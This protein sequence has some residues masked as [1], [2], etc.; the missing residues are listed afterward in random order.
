MSS[1][2]SPLITQ[3]Q[4]DPNLLERFHDTAV[5]LRTRLGRLAGVGLLVASGTLATFAAEE[6]VS[7]TPAYA[8]TL[9]YPWPTDTEAPCQFGATGSSSCTNPSNPSDKYDWGVNTGGV[10]HPYREAGGYEYRNCTD[11]VAWKEESLGASSSIVNGL[12]NG[13]QW[14]N[15]APASERSLTPRAGDAAVDTSGTFGHVA[16]VESVNYA[17][18]S[19]PLNDNITVSEY[20]HDIQGHGD[21]R[22]GKVSDLGFSKFVDFGVHPTGSTTPNPTSPNNQSGEGITMPGHWISGDSGQDFA[23]ITRRA[24]DGFDVAV[25]E[26]TPAGLVWKGVMQSVLGSSGVTYENTKFVATDMDGDGLMDLYYA[27]SANW[28]NPGFAMALFHNNGNGLDYWGQQWDPTNIALGQTKFLPGNWAGNG[29]GAFDYVTKNSD[30]GFS[31]AEFKSTASGLVWDGV[32]WT[33]AGSSGVTY[34]NTKFMPS[35]MDGDGKTDLYYA[36]ASNWAQPGF[37]MALQYNNGNGFTWAGQ[38]W[39]PNNLALQDVRL[40]PG[41]WTGTGKEGFAYITKN[42]DGGFSTAVF[43]STL[44]GLVWKGVWWTS[45]GSSQ[46]SYNNTL[47]VPADMDNDGKTDLFYAT[48]LNWNNPGFATA[49]MHSNGA[50]YDYWGQQW[51]PTNIALSQVTFMPES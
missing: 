42:S 28:N 18:P 33:S 40:I 20:N 7:S 35:D 5:D 24:D 32:R 34:D 49:L 36:T 43:D 25:W 9:G 27:T 1:E 11:Y 44:T 4:T 16:Y 45:P 51:D 8:D 21:F 26:Q 10:F 19:N 17:D 50:G 38:Q 23:Y 12:G 39:N 29:R 13:G 31:I 48:A 22:T 47:F 41:Y 3:E 37:A 2:L 46:V 14:Y 6:T 30:G 15:S